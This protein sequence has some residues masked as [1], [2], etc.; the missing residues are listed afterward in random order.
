[1]VTKRLMKSTWYPQ[2]HLII[3]GAS[4]ECD[5]ETL[6]STIVPF[7]FYDEGKGDPTAQETNPR[8]AAFA[9][10][11]DEANCFVDSSINNIF[12]EF[13]FSLTTFAMD[14][15]IPALR[16]A[17]MP[18]YMAF[19]E[20]YTAV[21]ELSSATIEDILE[22]QTESTDRQGGPLYVAAKD[23]LEKTANIGNLGVN[24]PFL[25]T[26]VGIEAV[27][28]VPGSYYN[29]LQFRTNGA[30]LRASTG[31]LQWHVIGTQRPFIRTRYNIRPKVKR[32]NEFTY[33]GLLIHFP[34]GGDGD[35]TVS[36]AEITA[37]KAMV[38]CDWNIRYN[39]WN[40]NFNARML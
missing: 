32:M 3:G 38:H 15:N 7:A 23:M 26:D 4:F 21:D 30:L 29:M 34:I 17:T 28:F 18:I 40:E 31:G 22:L 6:N 37:A 25:D 35:Q 24:T 8:N 9:V 36:A 1:M 39:E 12:A 10:I 14:D 2:P 19:L 5:D 27:A 20:N 13:R 11:A 16:F 33:C